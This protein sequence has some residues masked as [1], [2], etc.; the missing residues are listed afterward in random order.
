[1]WRVERVMTRVRQWLYPPA[2]RIAGFASQDG[3]AAFTDLLERIEVMS[4]RLE[5]LQLAQQRREALAPEL[6][7][8]ICNQHFRLLRALKSMP[9]EV[10][11]KEQ[12][13][14]R[15]VLRDLN[16]LLEDHGVECRDLEGQAYD[17]GRKDFRTDVDA[18]PVAGLE[19]SLIGPC[20]RPVVLL[21]GKL[22][23]QAVG[24]VQRPA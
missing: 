1:M 14:M 8:D 15:R 24:V 22:L 17:A 10:Q 19:R 13:Q 20:Q 18:V 16:E 21:D 4:Q 3:E 23:Q 11:T 7:V 9:A 2:F 6:A 5:G 12:R